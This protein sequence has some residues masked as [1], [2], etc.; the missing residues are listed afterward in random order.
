[1]SACKPRTPVTCVFLCAHPAQVVYFHWPSYRRV[2]QLSLAELAQ[3]DAAPQNILPL[4]LQIDP[5]VPVLYEHTRALCHTH[6]TT[7]AAP[8]AWL[9]VGGFFALGHHD[10]SVYVAR[11]VRELFL[12]YTAA[13]SA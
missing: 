11:D 3:S 12:H 13:D 6:A 1:M 10:G 9:Y 2:A 7:P 5:S 8:W 4:L